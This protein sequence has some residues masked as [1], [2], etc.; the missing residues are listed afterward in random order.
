MASK[1]TA[2]RPEFS[3]RLPSLKQDEETGNGVTDEEK[4]LYGMSQTSG[5]PIFTQKKDELLRDFD[6]VQSVAIASGKTRE[7]IGENAIIIDMAR[8][9]INRL[10]KF[11]EDSKEACESSAGK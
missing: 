2:I 9:V 8:G 6:D 11:I 4:F 10:W 7:E 5:W 3:L 1:K